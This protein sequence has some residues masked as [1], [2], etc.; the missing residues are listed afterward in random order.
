VCAVPET[1]DDEDT[2]VALLPL[3]G[4]APHAGRFAESGTAAARLISATIATR[5]VTRAGRSDLS[6]GQETICDRLRLRRDPLPRRRTYSS[7]S[8]RIVSSRA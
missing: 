1:P 5:T 8:A 4:I 3:S 6:I 7:P 2:V